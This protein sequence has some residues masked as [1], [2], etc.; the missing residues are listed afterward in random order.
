MILIAIN[1]YNFHLEIVYLICGKHM[2]FMVPLI[3]RCFY[4]STIPTQ[5][6]SQPIGGS[7]LGL[8]RK[9]DLLYKQKI[10]TFIT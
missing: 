7:K 8:Q 2:C 1:N 10:V 3:W 5:A 9:L 4:S 6:F